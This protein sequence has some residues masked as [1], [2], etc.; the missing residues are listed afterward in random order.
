MQA[1]DPFHWV[2]VIFAA[3]CTLRQGAGSTRLNFFRE[4]SR[5][6]TCLPSGFLPWRRH[7]LRIALEEESE[8]EGTEEGCPRMQTR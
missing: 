5:F 8:A 6:H 4:L 3:Y 2:I 1:P 7:V